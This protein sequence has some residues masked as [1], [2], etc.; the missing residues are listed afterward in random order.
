MKTINLKTGLFILLF[1][2]VFL[3]L[4]GQSIDSWITTGDASQLFQK[5]SS[6][7]FGTATNSTTISL[8]EG[9]TYQVMDGF[10][11]TFTEGSAEVISGLNQTQQDAL[12]NELFSSTTGIGVSV[13]RISIGASDMSS[14]DYSYNE[15]AADVNMTNF[16]LSGPDLTYLVPM[17]EKILL[18]N[19]TIKILATPWSAPRWMKSNNSW[20][21][22][23]LNAN[24]YAAYD[25]Y[26]LKYLDAMKALGINIWAI[27]PQNEPENPNNEP[28]MTMNST[29]ET[30]FINANL[31]PTIRNAGYNT[32]IIGYDH[33]CDDTVYPTAV[34]NN[35]TYVDGTAFHLYAGSI[36]AMSTVYNNTGKNVY[37]TEQY[38]GANGSFAGDFAWHTQ[39]VTLG[40]INNWSKIALEWNLATNSNY[41]PHTNGG[42]STCLGA[43]TV[44]NSATYY[45]N[46]SFYIIAQMAKVVLP[47]S[48]RIST[49]SS[50][51]N[52]IN[53]AFKSNDGTKA[54][55]VFNNTGSMATFD[56]K[57]NG[58][59][60]P[61]TLASG[62][63]GSYTWNGFLTGINNIISKDAT[64]IVSPNPVDNFVN[65]KFHSSDNFTALEILNTNGIRVSQKSITKGTSDMKIN[66]EN[67]KSGM[68][69]LK[70]KNEKTSMIEKFIKK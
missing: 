7:N 27:C 2:Q 15:T 14:S 61:C 44:A 29:E 48:V 19:P 12:L 39:N 52:L 24:E 56:V 69:Y 49:V 58:K 47:G 41:G 40:S 5:Q 9:I 62:G 70:L 42:C 11:Y 53:S 23:S 33:N 25:N 31:G 20:V 18:I 66:V 57:W 35:S 36:S 10:G 6:V 63:V 46:V 21:G 50:D 45:K 68:Y 65:V 3:A 51:N 1:T 4:Q 26:F 60:F 38:T 8:N 43:I 28:S 22:G 64:I 34:A 37:F 67:L 30:N 59:A 13:L 54:L 32:L 55:V 16:S 17:L